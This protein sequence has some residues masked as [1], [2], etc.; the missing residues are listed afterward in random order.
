MF[1]AAMFQL[2][3]NLESV[4]GSAFILESLRSGYYNHQWFQAIG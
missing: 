2:S 3:L 4:D 1:T